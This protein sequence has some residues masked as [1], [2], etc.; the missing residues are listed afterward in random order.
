LFSIILYNNVEFNAANTVGEIEL[1]YPKSTQVPPGPVIINI[2]IMWGWLPKYAGAI[3][4][5]FV[6]V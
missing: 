4:L 1:G 3:L 6:Y 5:S 2:V